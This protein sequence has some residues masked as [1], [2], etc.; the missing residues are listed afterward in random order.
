MLRCL[1]LFG[2]ILLLGTTFLNSCNYVSGPTPVVDQTS[3]SCDSVSHSFA[4][5]P[6]VKNVLVEK[7]SGHK[8]G[9]CPDASHEIENLSNTYG[10]R[11]IPVTIHP[12]PNNGFH[13]LVIENSPGSGDYE[14]IWYTE[15]GGD[16]M[17]SFTTPAFLPNGLVDRTLEPSFSNYWWHHT[18]WNAQI[19]SQLSK[20][21][22]VTMSTS[23]VSLS[24]GT[25]CGKT[26]VEFLNPVSTSGDYRI[27]HYLY[28]DS[29][30]DWQ[31]EHGTN[32]PNY[33]HRHVLR[34]VA[35]NDIIGQALVS[36]S[37]TV[38]SGTLDTVSYSFENFMV[39]DMSQL[40]VISFIYD[41]ETKEVMQTVS[42]K[43]S[44]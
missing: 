40:G 11:L 26:A 14:T 4:S 20:P 34:A 2:T 17:S 12:H 41:S 27:V 21:L 22:D 43:V 6:T 28:E 8:C 38:A 44:N 1:S 3:E 31:L 29:L 37:S 42:A 15:A 19:T 33:L 32:V 24:D 18:Q 30:A 7:F 5:A 9:N 13:S 23:N 16:I 36:G 39:R 10:S 25:V 35:N